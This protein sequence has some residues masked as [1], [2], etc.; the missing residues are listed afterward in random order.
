MTSEPAPLRRL[1][2]VERGGV[3]LERLADGS[4]RVHASTDL[5]LRLAPDA[6]W[7]PWSD[8]LVG[9]VEA[10]MLAHVKA[11]AEGAPACGAA[12]MPWWMRDANDTCP[13]TR[14]RA[15]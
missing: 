7:A 14:H 8:A 1:V 5:R 3:R 15:R 9:A 2:E 10:R 13:C 12:D 6:Y 4:T 11:L